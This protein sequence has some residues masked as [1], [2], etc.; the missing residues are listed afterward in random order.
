MQHHGAGLRRLR[1]TE[2]FI[3]GLVTDWRSAVAGDERLTAI[4]S[5][6]EVLT[7]EPAAVRRSDVDRMRE[8]GLDDEAILHVC[9]VASYFNYV[10]R[11]ADGLAVQ[12]EDHWDQPILRMPGDSASDRPR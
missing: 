5:Y 6:V 2:D 7:L 11:M 1:Q 12:L 3:Q 8:A 4:L 9:E 10:N